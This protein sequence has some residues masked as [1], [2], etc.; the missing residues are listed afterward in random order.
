[1]FFHLTDETKGQIIQGEL[2]QESQWT[3]PRSV[4]QTD[5]IISSYQSVALYICSKAW[6]VTP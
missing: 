3:C 6:F 1:M 5:V 4:S 2:T